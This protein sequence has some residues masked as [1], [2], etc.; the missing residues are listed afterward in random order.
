MVQM[1]GMPVPV[2][3]HKGRRGHNGRLLGGQNQESGATRCYHQDHLWRCQW[4]GSCTQH[5]IADGG[6][7]HTKLWAQSWNAAPQDLWSCVQAWTCRLLGIFGN[8]SQIM[9]SSP[10]QTSELRHCPCSALQSSCIL[11]THPSSI[12][13]SCAGTRTT[14]NANSRSGD[15]RMTRHYKV[16]QVLYLCTA[17]QK[18]V[19]L[20]P[21]VIT[22]WEHMLRKSERGTP[23]C[24]SMS[25]RMQMSHQNITNLLP[26][27]FL[28]SWIWTK[29][30]AWLQL[31][32]A[33]SWRRLSDALG[34]IQISTPRDPLDVGEWMLHWPEEWRPGMCGM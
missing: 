2:W 24:R 9:Q 23:C 31:H 26:H 15:L 25:S 16:T 14:Q 29:T 6:P 18:Y 4:P 30:K 28:C 17:I 8:P 13:T 3:R 32:V 34:Q 22:C 10:A 12:G 21:C 33:K 27:S 11:M 5:P 1:R 7:C 20:L 19:L